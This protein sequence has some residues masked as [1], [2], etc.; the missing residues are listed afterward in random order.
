MSSGV[1]SFKNSPRLLHFS[2]FGVTPSWWG[3][4]TAERGWTRKAQ[5]AREL[6]VG[7]SHWTTSSFCARHMT[8]MGAM[9]S[10]PSVPVSVE[11]CCRGL[12]NGNRSHSPTEPARS[13]CWGSRE[14][15]QK[16]TGSIPKNPNMSKIKDL[17]IIVLTRSACF[18]NVQWGI[19]IHS[20][21]S[22]MEDRSGALGGWRD[23]LC[24]FN[25][26]LGWSERRAWNLRIMLLPVIFPWN[27]SIEKIFFWLVRF[28]AGFPASWLWRD[29][30]G[31]RRLQPELLIVL[32]YH[33]CVDGLVRRWPNLW[34]LFRSLYLHRCQGSCFWQQSKTWRSLLQ[35]RSGVKYQITAVRALLS[36]LAAS[37]HLRHVYRPSVSLVQLSRQWVLQYRSD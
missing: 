3:G 14:A 17:P 32:R 29:S 33:I 6:P 12:P 26:R 25:P 13:L 10:V 11:L 1:F 18:W 27:Q 21:A 19:R 24:T 35:V 8:G 37:K 5:K 36:D 23:I 4:S 30:M 2:T 20:Q 31:L 16:A 15:K 7:P 9:I 34:I 28:T 22:L